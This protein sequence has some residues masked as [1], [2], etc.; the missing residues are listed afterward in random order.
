MASLTQHLCNIAHI[1]RSRGRSG[2]LESHRQKR[3]LSGPWIA[4]GTTGSS[5]SFLATDC[6]KSKQRVLPAIS[7]YCH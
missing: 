3:V 4:K 7:V 5:L 6:V 1:N 2:H